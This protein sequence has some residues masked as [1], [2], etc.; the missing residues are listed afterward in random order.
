M[1]WI[2]GV[3][4]LVLGLVAAGFGGA[5]TGAVLGFGFGWMVSDRPARPPGDGEVRGAPA[6]PLE[7][8]VLRLEQEL[9]AL[10]REMAS[11]RGETVGTPSATSATSATLAPGAAPGTV[12]AGELPSFAPPAS[13]AAPAPSIAAAI[14][15]PVVAA[16][17]PISTPTSAPA[18]AP[19]SARHVEP[20]LSSTLGPREPDFVERAI[21]AARGWLLGG[22]SV[23][24]VGILILF[25]G[26]AF[27]LKY[28]S[29]NAM[30]PV[31][32]RLAGVAAGAVVLLLAGWRLR[33][34]RAGYALVLQGGGVGVLYLTVFAATKL[35]GLLP[36]AAAFPLMVAIC[37][38]AGGLA[39]LQNAPALA[40]TGSAGGFL[41]PVLISTGGGS[42]V[43]LFSYY[44]LLNAGI[45]AIAWFRAWRQLNLLGFAFTFGIGN[46]YRHRAAL[47][48]APA[49]QPEG[50]RG[51]H[52]GVRHAAAGHGAA[53][54]AG[55]QHSIRHGM[56][57]GG[58]RGVLLR[59]GGVA[60]GAPRSLGAAV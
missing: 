32:F 3:I 11:L 34:R 50:L 59:A 49:G 25:F 60:G 29:D 53:G 20:P 24:R 41:A 18:T 4:G 51:R 7:A 10:R 13:V 15:I 46:V 14:P 56:E 9:S 44:A 54:R 27:L 40:F 36:A 23:V 39:V 1:R 16:P 58:A 52:A 26:V 28:A 38:L 48:A 33:E 19:A 47:C 30:L 6:D 17:A 22:N 57:R 31:E 35:Y 21:S 5:L 37:V 2:F 45:F 43:M 42:H 55:A 12:A 8:R